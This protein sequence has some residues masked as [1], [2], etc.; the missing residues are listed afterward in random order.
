[1]NSICLLGSDI[2]PSN[3][4]RPDGDKLTLGDVVREAQMRSRLSVQS[5][6][7]IVRRKGDM[8]ERLIQAV[9]NDWELEPYG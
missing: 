3:F 9:V 4:V 6:N 2:Q 7:R 8:S 5:W 1:M